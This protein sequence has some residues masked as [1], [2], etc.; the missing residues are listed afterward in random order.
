[1][2]VAWGDRY[3]HH[4]PIYRTSHAAFRLKAEIIFE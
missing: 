3:I 2:S 1:M 4:S